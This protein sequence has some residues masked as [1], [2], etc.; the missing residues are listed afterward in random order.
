MDKSQKIHN[1]SKHLVEEMGKEL[2]KLDL[3]AM[4]GLA[5]MLALASEFCVNAVSMATVQL[6]PI[7]ARSLLDQLINDLNKQIPERHA[8]F[9][10]FLEK[11]G[12]LKTDNSEVT[13]EV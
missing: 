8:A 2:N 1:I 5:A 6:P 7:I 9:H 11:S 3:N 13:V 12:V 10:E 4:E